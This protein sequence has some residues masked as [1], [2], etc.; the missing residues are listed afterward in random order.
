M[1]EEVLIIKMR[2]N[3]TEIKLVLEKIIL[4][5]KDAVLE[6]DVAEI[7][8]ESWRRFRYR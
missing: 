3:E 7:S 4:A 5:F 1:P 2:G 8:E 6:V